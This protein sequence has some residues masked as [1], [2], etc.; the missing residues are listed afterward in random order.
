MPSLGE[1]L[2]AAREARNLSLSDVS[3]RIH[4]RT[5][6]LQSLENEDYGT[7][8]APVYVRG[9]LRTYSRFLGL[10]PEEAVARFNAT[11]PDRDLPVPSRERRVATT[12][13][14]RSAS[15]SAGGPSPWLWILVAAAVI[16]VGYVGYSYYELQRDQH[17]LAVTP[18]AS[19]APEPAATAT[20]AAAAAPASDAPA[21]P[22]AAS[23]TAAATA[24]AATPSPQAGAAANALTVRVV[25]PSWLRVSVDGAVQMEGMYPAGTQRVFHGKA[26]TVRAGNAAGVEIT[27][28][29]RNLGPLGTTGEVVER[30]FSLPQQ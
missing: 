17:R 28:G 18:G 15:R 22:A 1:E 25:S 21:S 11:L 2:R 24:P 16:L 13:T 30:T 5:V 29:G 7:I 9:F 14:G 12:R 3:E 6:Y 23:A 19:A 27:A 4:I 10:D 8:A 20:P 26:A